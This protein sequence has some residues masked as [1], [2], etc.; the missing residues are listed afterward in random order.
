MA[1]ADQ[2][3]RLAGVRGAIAAKMAK[4]LQTA[5]QLSFHAECDVTD[6]LALRSRLNAA[7]RCGVED[8]LIL[9]LC[10]A[11]RAH[12]GLNG[13]VMDD[14]IE[15][16]AAIHVAVAIAL[17]GG[18]M[19][20]CL[21]DVQDMDLARIAAARADLVARARNG[22]LKVSEMTGGTI[23]LSNLGQSRVTY[24]TPVLNLPQIAILGVGRARDQLVDRGDGHPAKRTLMGLSLTV[25]HR[26]VD[27]G[28]AAAFLTALCEEIENVDRLPAG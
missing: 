24:F 27:G 13:H 20:P 16:R 21:F 15:L 23:T 26:A 4:S 11:L 10:R 17:P 5:A 18:L 1:L 25:D 7:G 12:P 2:T 9:A 6:L 14:R 22:A 28:P 19:A 8:L 3:I